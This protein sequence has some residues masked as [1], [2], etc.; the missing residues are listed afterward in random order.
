MYREAGDTFRRVPEVPVNSDIGPVAG[1]NGSA[2][3]PLT[4]AVF[5]A[6]AGDIHG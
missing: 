1:T 3:P 5:S 4:Q 2:G 6:P